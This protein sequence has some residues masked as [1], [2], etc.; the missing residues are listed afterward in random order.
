MRRCRMKR[1]PWC[2]DFDVPLT[3]QSFRAVP[4]KTSSAIPPIIWG[5]VY[6]VGAS[7]AGKVGLF[8]YAAEIKG[9]GVSSVRNRGAITTLANRR[10]A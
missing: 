2:P 6:A 7:V 10:L 3:A 5:P 4:G 1:R 8:E 9:A